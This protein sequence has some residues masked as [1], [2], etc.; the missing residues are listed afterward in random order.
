LLSNSFSLLQSV[1]VVVLVL[2]SLAREQTRAVPFCSPF[3]RYAKHNAN[4]VLV[5]SGSL[6]A[7]SPKK[8]V[9]IVY[10]L[11]IKAIELGSLVLVE[12]G[13]GVVGLK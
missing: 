10:N 5:V 9:E 3:A 1:L 13:V 8:V 2:D 6:K 12:F 4:F 11:L 7:E